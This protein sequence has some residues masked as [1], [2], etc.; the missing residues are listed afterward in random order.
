MKIVLGHLYPDY[1]NIYAD[2]GNMAVLDRRASWRGIELDYRPIGVEE[3]LA[4]GEYDL[5]YIG[6]GQF[7]HAPHTGDVVKVSNLG[8]SWYASTYVGARRP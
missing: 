4:P 1:L 7:V 6:G 3:P 2:R 8:D 5:L